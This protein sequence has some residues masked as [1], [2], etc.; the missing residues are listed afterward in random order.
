MTVANARP[1]DLYFYDQPEEMIAGRMEPPGCFLNAPAVLERQFTAFCFDRW[2]ETGVAGNAL[3]NRLG[4]VLSNLSKQDK[5]YI[6]PFSLL[7]FIENNR[8]TFFDKFILMFQKS[9]TSES[10]QN[11]KSFVEGNDGEQNLRYRIL[12]G[13]NSIDKEKRALQDKV[14]KLNYQIKQKENDPVKDKNYER[15][16]DDLRLEKAA[17]NG[18]HPINHQKGHFQLLHR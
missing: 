11:L 2:I 9:L 13:L 4:Q 18:M 16:L 8:T 10:A 6:F 12:N 1:H 14:K 17:M 15:D 7:D 5:K 3:P